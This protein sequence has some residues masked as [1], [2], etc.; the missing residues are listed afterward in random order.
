[1]ADLIKNSSHTG[2]I[3]T[4]DEGGEILTNNTPGEVDLDNL[5]EG[6]DYI[7]CTRPQRDIEKISND[8]ANVW[9]V[10]DGKNNYTSYGWQDKNIV[11]DHLINESTIALMI[12]AKEKFKYF[13]QQHRKKSSTQIYL[14]NHLGSN[15]WEQYYTAGGTAKKYL[16]VILHDIEF[17]RDYT[18]RNNVIE[19][20]IIVEGYE[21]V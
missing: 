14:I 6:R 13:I 20:K 8:F 18:N 15:A 2:Y 11:I 17:K 21:T 5:T 12:A 7:L 16:P 4:E 3:L 9:N 10:A 19:T 1:M